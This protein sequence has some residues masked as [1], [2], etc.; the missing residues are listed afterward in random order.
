MALVFGLEW[1]EDYDATCSSIGVW[2]EP[3]PASYVN[4]YVESVNGDKPSMVPWH[5]MYSVFAE[6]DMK[7]AFYDWANPD[8]LLKDRRKE[9]KYAGNVCIPWDN[10]STFN[11]QPWKKGDCALLIMELYDDYYD[12]EKFEE[13][14]DNVMRWD[15]DNDGCEEWNSTKS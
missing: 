14:C 7:R 6:G 8:T 1:D 3:D 15:F 9:M 2:P 4:L 13:G 11:P 10:W 12:C 5:T